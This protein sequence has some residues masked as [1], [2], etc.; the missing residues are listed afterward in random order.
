MARMKGIVKHQQTSS[1]VAMITPAGLGISNAQQGGVRDISRCFYVSC[2]VTQVGSSSTEKH[3]HTHTHVS[4][5]GKAGT[6]SR[7]HNDRPLALR[8]IA[9]AE[10]LM[11]GKGP[12]DQSFRYKSGG[13]GE[14]ISNSYFSSSTFFQSS[15]STTGFSD[16]RIFVTHFVS[17]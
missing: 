9:A 7:F 8:G 15:P 14:K 4:I 3:T 13:W 17:R 5:L 16:T 6:P 1:S 11:L 12:R 10:K 2:D